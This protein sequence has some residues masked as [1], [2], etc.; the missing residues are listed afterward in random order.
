MPLPLVITKTLLSPQQP[1]IAY[2][3][4]SRNQT[5][6]FEPFWA[7]KALFA[8]LEDSMKAKSSAR[9]GQITRELQRKVE[10]YSVG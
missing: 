9:Q 5:A 6:L 8:S 7:M 1:P 4:T 2:F 10:V 3:T